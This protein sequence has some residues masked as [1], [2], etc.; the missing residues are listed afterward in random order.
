[1]SDVIKT[2]ARIDNN[3]VIIITKHKEVGIYVTHFNEISLENICI[4]K[5]KFPDISL[6]K[7][8]K[9]NVKTV[10]CNNNLG[11]TDYIDL[12]IAGEEHS[13]TIIQARYKFEN[14]YVDEVTYLDDDDKSLSLYYF[15]KDN[16][17]ISSKYSRGDYS[18]ASCRILEYDPFKREVIKISKG[19]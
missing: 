16:N 15:P 18:A 6:E 13:R 9:T 10:Y 17:I 11:L 14:G 7:L 19:E 8:L 5:K 2:I 1:M 12:Y 3:L 4:W